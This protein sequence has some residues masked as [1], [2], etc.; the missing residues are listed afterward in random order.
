LRNQSYVIDLSTRGSRMTVEDFTVQDAAPFAL[1]VQGDTAEFFPG[2]RSV[3]AL[4]VTRPRRALVDIG[5]EA[6]PASPTE[7]RKWVESC[8][9]RDVTARHVVSDLQPRAT[10]NLHCDGRKVGSFEADSAGRI[11]FKRTL[12][13]A[14]PQRFE[15]LIQ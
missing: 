9:G 1:N 14:K 7:P 15:L 3:P 5:I 10:Y 11:E 13:H 12:N 8:P 4:S 2:G 6:W